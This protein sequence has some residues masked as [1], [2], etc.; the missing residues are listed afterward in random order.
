MVRVALIG[1]GAVAVQPPRAIIEELTVRPA[2]QD[3]VSRR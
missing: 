3:W 2:A 1:T